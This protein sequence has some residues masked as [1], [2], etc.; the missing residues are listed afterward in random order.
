MTTV[1]CLRKV[2][3]SKCLRKVSKE[4]GCLIRKSH[5]LS[6]LSYLISF[7]LLVWFLQI[8]YER[9]LLDIQREWALMKIVTFRVEGP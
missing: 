2:V 1:K 9:T 5:P 8:F 3:N 7:L 6:E 4:S